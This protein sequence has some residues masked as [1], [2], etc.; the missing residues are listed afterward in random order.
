[1]CKAVSFVL[2]DVLIFYRADDCLEF[3]GIGPLY[4]GSVIGGICF[5][6]FFSIDTPNRSQIEMHVD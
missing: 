2:G 4:A 1:M 6:S 5:D 3:Y